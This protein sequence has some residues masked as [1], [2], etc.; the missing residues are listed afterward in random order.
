M[1]RRDR[2]PIRDDD[3]PVRP[4]TVAQARREGMSDARIRSSEFA[5][6]FHGVRAAHGVERDVTA[7]AHAYAVKMRRDAVFSHVTAAQLLGLPLPSRFGPSPLHVLVPTGTAPVRGRGIRGHHAERM[8]EPVRLDGLRVLP[9]AETWA[10]LGAHLEVPDLVAV[11][12]AIIVRDPASVG[13]ASL[14]RL[15]DVLEGWRSTRGSVALRGAI[16][17]IR[18]GAASR[19]ESLLRVLLTAA[20]FPEPVL[21]L[22]VP[23]SASIV[24]LAWPELRFGIEYDGGYHRSARQYGVDLGRQEAIHDLGWLLMRVRKEELFGD[25]LLVVERA[26]RR[27]AHRGYVLPAVEI[28]QTVV[29]RP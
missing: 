11:G 6:P 20:G 23:G 16:D 24:D 15:R 29:P 9:P 25:P 7:L 5:A 28:S 2:Y 1:P 27:F 22:R 13:H 19:P 10:T 3:A 17:G 18:L 12:D 14:T 4:F 8:P 21:N 26:R